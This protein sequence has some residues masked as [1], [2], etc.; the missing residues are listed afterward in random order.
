MQEKMLKITNN[1]ILVVVQCENM[2][3][4]ADSQ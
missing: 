1:V 3:R 4:K 2:N